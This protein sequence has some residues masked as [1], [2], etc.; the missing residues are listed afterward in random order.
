MEST[1]DTSWTNVGSPGTTDKSTATPA[2]IPYGPR[3]YLVTNAN[4]NEGTRST[5]IR[6]PHG[7]QASAYAVAAALVGTASLQL[8]DTTNS[9]DI[10]TAVTHSY[11]RPM[12][13][14]I[15][16]QELPATCRT[17]QLS[18]LGQE[19]S[20]SVLWNQVGLYF[21]D[22]PLL[23]LPAFITESFMA[24]RLYMGVPQYQIATDVYDATSLRFEPL[25]A[26]VD[27]RLV[28]NHNDAMP[29]K[30]QM[31]RGD[32]PWPVFVEYRRSLN[33]IHGDVDAD[34]DTLNGVIN[35]I[36]PKLKVELLQS[37]YNTGIRR[38]DDWD[39]QYNLA[40]DQ[41]RK[42]QLARPILAQGEPKPWLS[43]RSVY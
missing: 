30:V 33:D 35:T 7:R 37:V 18:M 19:A 14:V 32:F 25:T 43:Y 2:L 6:A 24:P 16:N 38:I 1:T 36:V 3:G 27:Y 42:S 13:M 15:R 31:L 23:Q 12:L 4:A 26:G 9:A 41:I 5:Q 10:G 20:A 8:R 39:I 34:T 22:T 17:V 29:Y 40:N 28:L 11:N 21:H